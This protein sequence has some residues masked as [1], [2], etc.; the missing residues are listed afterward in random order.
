MEP[1]DL[2]VLSTFRSIADA[3]IARGILDEAGIESMIRSDNGGGMLPAM[4]GA[5]LLVRTVDAGRARDALEG[6]AGAQAPD[7][8]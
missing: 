1:A 6:G 7:D 3:E 2:I 8:E 5:E 4:A